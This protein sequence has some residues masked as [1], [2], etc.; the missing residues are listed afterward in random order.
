MIGQVCAFARVI[1]SNSCIFCRNRMGPNDLK[2]L[3]RVGKINRRR[4]FAGMVLS[5][6]FFAVGDAKWLEPSWVKTRTVRLRRGTAKVRFVHFTD[7]HHKGDR[8][9]FE[10][11]VK[12]INALSPEFVCFTG[13]LIEET[14]HLPEALETDADGDKERVVVVN[15]EDHLRLPRAGAAPRSGGRAREQRE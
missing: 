1:W 4:F 15:D 13:D 8:A 12:K 14:R 3:A 5:A 10:S 2:R 11:V 9:Y 6:P 7:V